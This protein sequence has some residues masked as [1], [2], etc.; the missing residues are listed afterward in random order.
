[1]LTSLEL[2]LIIRITAIRRQCHRIGSCLSPAGDLRTRGVH[3]LSVHGTRRSGACCYKTLSLRTLTRREPEVSPLCRLATFLLEQLDGLPLLSQRAVDVRPVHSSA[4]VSDA[5]GHQRLELCDVLH[6]STEGYR[7]ISGLN[8]RELT[9]ITVLTMTPC[10]TAFDGRRT[11]E[12]SSLQEAYFRLIK[13]T[14][15][16]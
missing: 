6:L 5:G 15:L 1:M 8:L 13:V 9:N 12:V 16:L 14:I 2:S 7:H 10:G 11:K 4:D 3:Y